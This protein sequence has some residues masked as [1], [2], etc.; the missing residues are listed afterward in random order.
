M[1]QA[2]MSVFVWTLI[3]A[4]VLHTVIRILRRFYKFPIPSFLVNLID[5]PLRRRVQAPQRLAESLD[6]GEGALVLEVG[7]GS[8]TYTHAISTSVGM[9]GIIISLDIEPYVLKGLQTRMEELDV[10]NVF[11][12]IADVHA[13]PFP[14]GTFDAVYMI[15][16][17]GE[18]PKAKDA[19]RAFYAVLK[20]GGKL[21]FSELLF[22][23][24]FLLPRTLRT[25]ADEVGFR[26][27]QREGNLLSYTLTFIRP[28]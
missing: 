7:P 19:V 26:P 15:T 11:S 12:L 8:G 27:H 14:G 13:L 16:V 28:G 17:I 1:L 20:P 6:V 18:I 2:I 9:E 24:D 25:W 22:D 21:M 23:P 10:H 3:L 4:F 5:N